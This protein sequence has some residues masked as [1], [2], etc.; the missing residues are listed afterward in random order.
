M[1]K[2]ILGIGLLSM[3]LMAGY[4]STPFEGK[5][6]CVLG[7]SYVRN[8]R[9]PVE[10]SW[11]YKLASLLKMDYKNFGRNGSSIAFDRTK[12]GFGP[13]MTVRYKEMPDSADFVI[14]IAGHNDAGCIDKLG[15]WEEFQTGLEEL[16]TGLRKKYPE[17]KI[18]FIT[19]WG[20][21][22]PYFKEVT[23]EIERICKEYGFPV[24]NT[25]SSEIIDVNNPEFRKLYFQGEND[26]AHLNDRGHNLMI[27][28]GQRFLD[29][30][31]EQNL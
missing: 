3:G 15:T 14:V 19:P 31:L 18:G 13:A 5:S 10:E 22:R 20:V 27:S 17:A 6:I 7:D 11:H 28:L 2:L 8:H 1:K 26:T 12:E 25:T 30:L 24:L 4:A 21:D 9:C 29:K 16:C 23:A